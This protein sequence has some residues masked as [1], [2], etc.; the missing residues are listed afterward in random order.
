MSDGAAPAL[1]LSIG[2]TNFAAVT[3]DH[4][5][6]RKPVMTLYRERLPEIGVP[7]ENPRLDQPGL[8]IT[9]FVD[10]VGDP[11][12]I[13]A[14]DGSVHQSEALAADGLRA[15]AY[16]AAGRELPENVAVTHP[17]HW[18]SNAVNALGSALS[19]V[20]EWT[21]RAQPLTLIPDA[22][23]TLFAVRANPGIPARG[24]VAVCD[25]GGSG[26]SITLMD[27]AGDYYPL[28]PTVRHL[29]FS[30]DLID[31]ALLT[32]VLANLPSAASF[33]PSGTSAIGPLGRLRTGCRNA[34]EQLSSSTVATLS[35]RLPG[36]PGEVRLTRNELDDA[37]RTSLT[38]F[39]TVL[40]ETLARNGIRDLVAV[41]SVGG[42][43]NIPA[44]TT[45]LSG[46]L[47]V[48]V[49]TMPRPHLAPAIGGALR[50]TRGPGETS[51]T[52]LTPA[53]SRATAAAVAAA[54]AA[55]VAV[56]EHK[57]VLTQAPPSEP[58]SS[59]MPAL[60]W[61]EAAD[62][63]RVMPVG[64]ATHGGGS[65]YTSARPAMNFDQPERPQREKKTSVIPWH[66]M[67]GMVIISTAVAVLLVG[68]ALAIGLSDNKP[69]T[70]P[71]PG[72]GTSPVSAPPP[73]SGAP[74]PAP[75]S[76]APIT[77]QAATPAEPAAPPPADAPA[78]APVAVDTPPPAAVDT[79]VPAAPSPPVEAPAPPPVPQIPAPAPRV[80]PIPAIPPIPR[81][82]GFGMP[83]PGLGGS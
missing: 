39:V 22:A 44:V 76:Q 47:R 62:D 68:V 72:V 65:G 80:P 15:L 54:V 11:I 82:P 30:G 29:D 23:A 69:A 4:A 63:S 66:R 41:V 27:A 61:S 33:D 12:G 73:N 1:G 45:M 8:V 52:L 57:S 64:A 59:L 25:F 53:A 55:P 75:A 24:T 9:G 34:K 78:P 38:N 19:R 51:A 36:I 5:V 28:A 81:I 17:A 18:G 70:T 67:P 56:E 14:A 20:P 31:Q 21:N 46:H 74:Q 49:V 43:A 13:V 35:E 40:D 79:P 10:R 16:A 58:V 71:S 26:T 42:G 83:I 60:A 77:G 3:A 7:A 32:T 50:A 37:I 6:T 48:P 2:A